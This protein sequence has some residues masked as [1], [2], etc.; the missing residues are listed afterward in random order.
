MVMAVV[1]V[2]I[3]RV[4]VR[5]DLV[6]MRMGVGFGAVPGKRVGVLM[7]LIVLW[8]TLYIN[9]ILERLRKEGYPVT[10]EDAARLSPL[11]HDHANM[12]GRYSFTVPE[13]VTRGELRPLRDPHEEEGA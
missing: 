5:D 11:I 6:A 2:G 3:V 12:L 10:D 8:N 1:N 4:A 13:N 9:A 7:V